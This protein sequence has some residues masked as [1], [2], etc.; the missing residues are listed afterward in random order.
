MIQKFAKPKSL[1][2]SWLTTWLK[3]VALVASLS[4]LALLYRAWD[5]GIATVLDEEF[6]KS[7][8]AAVSACIIA[9]V[10]LS[11]VLLVFEIIDSHKN[12]A[13]GKN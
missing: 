4:G 8:L 3:L 5:S 9:T 11:F 7:L 12:G 10:P 2:S 13:S 1:A 6:L